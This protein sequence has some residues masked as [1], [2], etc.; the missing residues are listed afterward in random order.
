MKLISALALTLWVGLVP[1]ASAGLLGFLVLG[2]VVLGAL[3]DIAPARLLARAA[4]VLPFVL[5]PAALGLLAG[6]LD[7]RAVAVMA[8]R[9][10]G[11]ATVGALL[12]AV[13]PFPALLGA[14][15]AIRVPHLLVQT[16]ALTYRYLQVLRERAAALTAGARA[17]GYGPA[18]PHRFAVAGSMIG[19][20]LLTSLDRSERVHGAMLARG[21]AGRFPL[22]REM[23]LR[24][25]DWA[26]G[27][28][29]V[30][31]VAASLVWMR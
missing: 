11:A 24:W 7:P 23:R 22:A 13:T 27:A 12:V 1:A 19:A 2:V 4:I 8:A 5:L 25:V 30:S 28:G 29:I 17:R 20:L 21:Y 9:S 3:A 16:T 6:T 26:V 10:Y 14:A 15:P 31:G 18:T